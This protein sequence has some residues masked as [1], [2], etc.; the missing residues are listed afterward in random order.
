MCFFL[1]LQSS[2][3]FKCDPNLVV[4][5][6]WIDTL[7]SRLPRLALFARRNIQEGEE[8]TFDYQMNHNMSLSY[9]Q[10]RT[11]CLCGTKKCRGF[12]F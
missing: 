7:D 9:S 2:S 4:F 10:D 12:L 11:P 8:L 6:V 3:L 5:P 1:F